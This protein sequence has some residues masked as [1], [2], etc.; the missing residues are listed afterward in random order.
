MHISVLTLFPELF[1]ATL[2]LGVVGR[3]VVSGQLDVKLINPRDYAEDKHRTVDDRPFGG[4]A[5]MVL[6]FEP[7][8]RALEVAKGALDKAGVKNAPTVLMSPQGTTFSQDMAVEASTTD[9]MVFVCGRY[10]G[11]DQRFIDTYIDAEWSIG[12]YVI[13][14]GELAAMVVIDALARHIPGT[15]GNQQSIF[16]ESYLD[17]RL[18]YPQYTRPENTANSRVPAVLLSGDHNRIAE[19]RRAEALRVTYTRRPELLTRKIFGSEDK[20]HLKAVI[21]AEKMR[22]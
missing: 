16:D 7:L 4:G 18:D 17:D 19:F 6:M 11:L 3:A 15:L 12:D 8:Q 10:E 22:S 20:I 5:G 2:K 13:S 9:G 14:G 21:E 1:A